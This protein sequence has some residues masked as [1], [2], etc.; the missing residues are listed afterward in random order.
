[1]VEI[2]VAPV[3]GVVAVRT[4]PVEMVVRPEARAPNNLKYVEEVFLL[5]RCRKWDVPGRSGCG[6]MDRLAGPEEMDRAPAEPEVGIARAEDT[7]VVR[8]GDI[9]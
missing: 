2:G 7:F 4:L 8:T 6:M 3:A 9:G 5:E 1:M